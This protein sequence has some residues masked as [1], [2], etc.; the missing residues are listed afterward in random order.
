M[1][2]S[3]FE[4]AAV[5]FLMTCLPQGGLV[6]TE[7][8]PSSSGAGHGVWQP[9][10][11]RVFAIRIVALWQD[12]TGLPLGTLRVDGQVTVDE[13]DYGCEARFTAEV[14]TAAGQL[15]IADRG[16]AQGTRIGFD[17]LAMSNAA[18]SGTIGG[19]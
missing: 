18:H 1:I 17:A 8:W 3:L 19:Q 13:T 14:R 7:L 12:E 4:H 11:D 15:T 16:T 10:G 5:P 9:Q 6:T 2:G